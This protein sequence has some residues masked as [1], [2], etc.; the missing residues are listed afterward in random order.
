MARLWSFDIRFRS[1]TFPTLIGVLYEQKDLICRV[2]FVESRLGYVAPGDVLV[3]NREEGLKQPGNLP[4]ELSREIQRCI[5]Q[6]GL[7]KSNKG[8]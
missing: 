1:Q 4:Q 2:H 8:D 5:C 6:A 3:Y 7:D